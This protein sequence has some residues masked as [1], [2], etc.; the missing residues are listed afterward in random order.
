[1][2]VQLLQLGRGATAQAD[3]VGVRGQGFAFGS[4]VRGVVRE[5]TP[6][7]TWIAFRFGVG[8]GFGLG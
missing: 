5:R 8:F 1:M 2:P 4:V 7:L 3:L 6:R